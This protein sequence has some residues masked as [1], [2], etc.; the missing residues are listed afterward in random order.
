VS[1]V[2]LVK[3]VVQ[4]AFWFAAGVIAFLS[5]NQARKSIF[6]PA[7][8][9]V[10]RAQIENL[11]ELVHKLNWKSGLEAWE[12]SGLKASAD[13][14][15]HTQFKDY[16][17]ERFSAVIVSSQVETISSVGAIFSTNATGFGLIQGPA[18]SSDE[19]GDWTKKPINWE[20]Y[21]WE[22]FEISAG[23]QE[24]V[25]LLNVALNNPVLPRVVISMLQSLQQE[26][27]DTA[28]RAAQDLEKI[29]REFPRH[30]PTK[31]SLAGANLTWASNMR[32]ER[33]Q[34]LYDKLNELKQTIRGYLKTDEL[35]GV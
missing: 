1:V 16:A 33:G 34:R 27:D 31:E 24:I 6:Q 25:E 13:I 8:N 12:Y 35:F 28:I 5:Y 7:K 17:E 18:D 14:S 15:L 11:Q 30:Y 26:L 20:N 4:I 2:A 32:H 21:V 29:V 19:N 9:E 10:F 3:D 23:H 22:I